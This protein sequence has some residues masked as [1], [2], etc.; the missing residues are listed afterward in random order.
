[1]NVLW[2]LASFLLST[3]GAPPAHAEPPLVRISCEDEPASLDWQK[4]E[5]PIER[6][7]S[8]FV[9][10][11]N[12]AT[13]ER[14]RRIVFEANPSNPGRRPAY[15]VEMI[16]G[17]HEK[18]MDR[19][20]RGQIDVFVGPSADDILSVP[21]ARIEVHPGFGGRYLVWSA[22]NSKNKALLEAVSAALPLG[23]LPAATRLGDQAIPQTAFN[24][25]RARTLRETT[26]GAHLLTLS[27]LVRGQSVERRVAAWVG[28][29][30]QPLRI[31]LRVIEKNGGDYWTSLKSGQT[32][33]ALVSWS[34][35]ADR[36]DELRAFVG[37]SRVLLKLSQPMHAFLL[38]KR[39]KK[40][41]VDPAGAPLLN[42]FDLQEGP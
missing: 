38:S 35:A 41:A 31:S 19:F 27:L 4:G 14:G 29:Q 3:L 32:D 22:A 42:A 26:L 36:D 21:D 1:M 37:K 10:P 18:L 6:F 9:G 7:L 16:F 34:T 8:A 25:E 23:K 12:V 13:W 5:T 40:F 24:I 15:R 20:R 17:S 33:L 2:P 11:Y 28:E 30:L 39:V